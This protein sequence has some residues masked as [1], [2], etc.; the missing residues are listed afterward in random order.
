MGIFGNMFGGTEDTEPKSKKKSYLNWL[1][2]TSIEQLETIKNESNTGAVLIFKHSTRCGISKMVIKQFE[3]LFTADHENLKVY[4][5]DLLNYRNI[6]D[7]VGYSFQVIHASPQ[8]IIVRN[9]TAVHNASHEDISL[10]NLSR[11][12]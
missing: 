7:E 10:T 8:L 2:L 12:I 6:S 4:Y 11:F 3:K 5:L 1:P 9:G